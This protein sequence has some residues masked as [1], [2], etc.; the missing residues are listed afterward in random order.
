[1]LASTSQDHEVAIPQDFAARENLLNLGVPFPSSPDTTPMKV[2]VP[3][4]SA[5]SLEWN[6][7][8]L[9][10]GPPPGLEWNPLGIDPGPPPGLESSS[11]TECPEEQRNL[12]CEIGRH[13]VKSLHSQYNV[14]PGLPLASQH[15]ASDLNDPDAENSTQ[16]KEENTVLKLEIARLQRQ[17]TVL[18]QRREQ[19]TLQEQQR[20]QQPQPETRDRT[21]QQPRQVGLQ[22]STEAPMPCFAPLAHGKLD[23]PNRGA[24]KVG[25]IS[26]SM[27]RS[28]DA[29]SSV[30][31]SSDDGGELGHGVRTTQMMQNVPLL[32]GQIILLNGLGFAG[33]LPLD[34]KTK[35]SLGSAFLPIPVATQSLNAFDCFPTEALGPNWA[36]VECS[37][38]SPVMP[39][40]VPEECGPLIFGTGE[41]DKN[42]RE[43]RQRRH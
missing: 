33:N 14:S 30:P 4:E 3:R 29:V 40:S 7:L 43:R 11:V 21:R 26:Q 35:R 15:L 20:H 12:E 28:T 22:P 16:L 23:E 25:Y 2:H 24:K 1:M 8:D 32:H 36:H 39:P 34:F 31:C 27:D 5:G 6:P 9:D 17:M 10:P 38:S 42:I 37:G 18:S 13:L 19:R 41:P